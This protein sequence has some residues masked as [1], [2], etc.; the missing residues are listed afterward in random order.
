MLGKCFDYSIEQGM[1][2]FK[3]V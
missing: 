3:Y 1:S 2:Y